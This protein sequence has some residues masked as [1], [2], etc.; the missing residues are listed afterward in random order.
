MNN[1]LSLL[2]LMCEMEMF[3]LMVAASQ[4]TKQRAEHKARCKDTVLVLWLS[5]GTNAP[6]PIVL[7]FFSL[8]SYLMLSYAY[9]T[10]LVKKKKKKQ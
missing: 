4:Q 5:S 1:L 7:T 6:K 2:S 10:L 3:T 9:L 8:M